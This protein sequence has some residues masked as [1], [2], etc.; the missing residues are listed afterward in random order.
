MTK[1]VFV[2]FI[3]IFSFCYTCSAQILPDTITQQRCLPLLIIKF[4]PLSAVD[5]N[6]TYQF[7]IEYPLNR[8][9]SVQQ[10]IGYGNDRFSIRTIQTPSR[11]ENVWRL[12]SEVRR[13]FDLPS[14]PSHSTTYLALE[15]FYK[16]VNYPTTE[17]IGRECDRG[18]CAYFETVQ[19]TFQKDV[20]GSHFKL[21]CHLPIEK[22]F[23][24]DMYAG[25]GFRFIVVKSPDTLNEN[26]M[27]SS[28][29]GFGF[30]FTRQPGTYKFFSFS[31]GIKLGYIF[32]RK[33]K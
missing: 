29:E 19:Y 27:L 20:V 23:L 3:F 26:D 12:R 10:D 13:Y 28:G 14:D 25:V 8:R 1:N 6:A 2:T 21:G 32:Y 9:W 18:N 30:N 7:A 5:I 17:N 15:A 24:I 16:Q 31:L 22:R 4:S 33:S 11:Q